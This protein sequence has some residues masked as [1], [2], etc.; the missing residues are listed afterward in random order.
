MSLQQIYNVADF[1][2]YRP[3][4][5][6][7]GYSK[8]GTLIGVLATFS[9]I[10]FLIAITTYYMIQLKIN[11]SLTTIISNRSRK[12][13]DIIIFNKNS[14]FFAFCLENPETSSCFINESIYTYKVSYRKGVK[15]E[16]GIFKYN[17]TV[18]NVTRCSKTYF[19]E[20]YHK[21]INTILLLHLINLNLFIVI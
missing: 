2:G 17:S 21:I 5:F 11:K 12:E 20:K 1:Y 8:N 7:G 15:N 19:G 6:I 10:I 4:F 14:S 13:D 3:K 9:S 16:E 18:L